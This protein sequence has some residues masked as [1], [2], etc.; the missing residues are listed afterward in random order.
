MQ[1][2]ENGKEDGQLGSNVDFGGDG[3]CHEGGPD[4]GGADADAD[5]EEVEPVLANGLSPGTSPQLETHHLDA[6]CQV[7]S[8]MVQAMSRYESVP[9][10]HGKVA[11]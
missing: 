10:L 7:P 8:C 5:M 1:E 9:K 11:S 6:R 2:L 4:N 3:E